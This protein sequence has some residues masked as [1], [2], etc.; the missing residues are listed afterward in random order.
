M[1]ETSSGAALSLPRSGPEREA[2][3]AKGQFWTPDWVAD[4][5]ASYVLRARPPELLDP[6]MGA[7]A[8]LRAA[9]RCAQES[10]FPLL[11][12]GID[13]DSNILPQARENGL[14]EQDLSH[15]EIRDFVLNPPER[16]FPAI[17]ANP[18]YIRHHRLSPENKTRLR[19]FAFASTGLRLDGRAGFHVYFLLQA[20]MRLSPHGRM[21]FIVSSDICEGVFAEN[22][23]RWI[24]GHY[25]LDAVITFS[26]ESSPFPHV[27]TNAVVFLIAREAPE[28]NFLWVKCHSRNAQELIRFVETIPRIPPCAN[29][30]IYSRS[31]REGLATGLARSPASGSCRYRLGDFATVMRGIATGNNE[32]FFLTSAQARE[33]DIPSSCLVRAIGRTRDVRGDTL[34]PEDMDILDA[35]GRPTWL[36]A[37]NGA[38]IESL[39]APVQDYLK[40]G[41]RSGL[42]GKTLIKTRKPWY[43]M[44]VRRVPPILFAYL[45]RRNARFIRNR[46]SV[47]PLTCLLCVYPRFHDMVFTEKLWEVLSH[48]S[49]IA[50]LRKVGKSYGG[51][52][53]K[54]EPRALERLPLPDGLVSSCELERWLSPAQLTLRFE[55]T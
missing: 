31:I 29:L 38:P 30:E 43:R 54:V 36:L 15:V 52:A 13:V 41:E 37:I 49:T 44:E 47:V 4:W 51:G 12:H 35:A 9:K 25:R 16:Q 40:N 1:N 23:W 46:A 8:F 45:G 42:P 50:N 3:R 6:A 20:L 32:F 18:P 14:S 27:D 22:L 26:R 34:T 21:A 10:G 33:L 19:D 28:E 55:E 39:P 17:L 24:C 5:M 11:L 53:V 48:P 7:G 2:L